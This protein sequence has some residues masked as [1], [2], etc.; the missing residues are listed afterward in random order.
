MVLME[1]VKQAWILEGWSKTIGYK[2]F[3]K[4]ILFGFGQRGENLRYP[5]I[6]Q[7]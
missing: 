4:T 2:S 6:D 5:L 7:F 1:V 3:N